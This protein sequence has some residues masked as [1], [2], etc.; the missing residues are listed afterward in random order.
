MRILKKLRLLYNVIDD[1]QGIENYIRLRLEE[2]DP[3]I[4]YH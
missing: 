3:L 1:G 2:I 4:G